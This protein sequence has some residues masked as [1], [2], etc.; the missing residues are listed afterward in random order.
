VG[1]HSAPDN[2]SEAPPFEGATVAV[3][4][5]AISRGRHARPEEDESGPTAIDDTAKI[6]RVNLVEESTAE[7]IWTPIDRML[8]DEPALDEPALDEPGVQQA[9]VDQPPATQPT[10]R[11]HERSTAADFALV[12]AH[13]DVRARVLAAVLVPFVVYTVAMAVLGKLDRS[14]LLW[15]WA[16]L[17]SAG[18]LVGLF[19]DLGHRKYNR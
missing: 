8:V 10:K 19:L 17:I 9:T 11:R 15:I 13:G 5:P 16:P 1:R 2:D 7:P 6:A 3:A 14:Y 18:V 4:A 12:R